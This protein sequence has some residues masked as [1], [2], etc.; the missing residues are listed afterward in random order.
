MSNEKP[1]SL[2][3]RL[4]AAAGCLFGCAVMAWIAMRLIQD[5]WIPLVIT[6]AVLVVLGTG[7][8]ILRRRRW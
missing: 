4:W 6:L 7:I 3:S 2:L 1:S 5:V 8:A